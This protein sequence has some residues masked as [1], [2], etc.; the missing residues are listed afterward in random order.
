[1]FKHETICKEI[2]ELAE[3]P[4]TMHT[5]VALAC[6]LYI[7]DH[8]HELP[9]HLHDG[10]D[11]ESHGLTMDAAEEWVHHMENADG[12]SGPHWTMTETEEVRTKHGIDCEPLAFW[13][14]MNMMYSDYV[15]AAKYCGIN[16]VEFYVHMA[17]AF[18]KDSDARPDKLERYYRHIARH[19]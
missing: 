19:G 1:M 12:S 17:E 18:L 13:V 3:G 8:E 2:K 6:M 15:C 14:A 16:T 11:Q 10:E 7:K 4:V 5:T 9:A